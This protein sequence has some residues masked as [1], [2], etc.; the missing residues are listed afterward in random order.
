MR[1]IAGRPRLMRGS[2][3]AAWWSFRTRRARFLLSGL[4]SRFAAWRML[5]APRVDWLWCVF[6]LLVM[7]TQLMAQPETY[8]SETP[9]G[10]GRRRHPD[11][12]RSVTIAKQGIVATSHPLAS[13]AGLEILKAGGNAVDA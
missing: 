7:V 8:T 13:Q 3:V 6:V 4:K 5:M 11:Q 1:M 2:E 12:T 9:G 10:Y